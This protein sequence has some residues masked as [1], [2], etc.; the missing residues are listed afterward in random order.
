MLIYRNLL[1]YSYLTLFK[2]SD[3]IDFIGFFFILLYLYLFINI[4]R[5]QTKKDGKTLAKIKL[6]RILID[7]SFI[8]YTNDHTSQAVMRGQ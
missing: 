8:C 1:L 4:C 6:T 2:V 3:L 5:F 7:T